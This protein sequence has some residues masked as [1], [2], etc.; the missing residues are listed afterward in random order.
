MTAAFNFTRKTLPQKEG[1]GEKLTKKRIASGYDIRD[2]EKSIRIRA[3]YIEAIESGNYDKL[4]PDVFVRGFIKNY[5]SFLKLDPEKVLK[6]YE[7]E[8][9]LIENVKKATS[10]APIVKPIDAPKIVITPK[11]I[12]V[13]TVVLIALI[14]VSY[15]GWQVRILTAPPDLALDSPGNN[16]NVSS[17][18]LFVSGKTDTG[19]TLFVNDVEIGVDQDGSFKEKVSLQNGVNTIKVKA[20]NKL[21][22]TKEVT[23]TVV[24]AI[25]PVVITTQTGVQ[26]G[27]E[28]KLTIGP[29]SA[30]VQ[31]E[32]D[33][34]KL[35]EKSIVVLAGVT[36][37]YKANEQIIVTTDNGGSVHAIYNG[38][39]AGILGKDG[40]QVK[41]TFD[42]NMEIK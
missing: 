16:V 14:I 6:T 37:T 1:L 15:I 41:R 4:P 18:S 11:T 33:G 7:K 42:K 21:G 30:Q 39:D 31:V 19:A 5:A 28:L 23:R 8:R 2:V 17:D 34:K 20:Q 32:V 13:S 27:L 36:Q 40:E 24:A 22:K 38:K 3:K 35:T 9:G 10:K 29:K 12:I 25:S 26:S